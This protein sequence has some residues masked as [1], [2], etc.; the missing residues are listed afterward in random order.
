MAVCDVPCT[1]KPKLEKLTAVS[2][3][4]VEKSALNKTCELDSTPTWS[5]KESENFW[6]CCCSTGH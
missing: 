1:A 4:K 5:V 2:V 3:E 6:P